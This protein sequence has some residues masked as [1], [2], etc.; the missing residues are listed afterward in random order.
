MTGG[1]P[2]TVWIFG[3]AVAAGGCAGAAAAMKSQA[4]MTGGTI[5]KKADSV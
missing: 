3:G 5:R 4:I 2:A 1:M